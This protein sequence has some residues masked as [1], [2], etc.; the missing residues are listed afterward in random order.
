MVEGLVAV[1][2]RGASARLLVDWRRDLVAD[3]GGESAV[4]A[5][6]RALV[7]VITRTKLYV[8]HLDA[9]LMAQRSLVNK[10]NKGPRKH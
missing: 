7:E 1:D 5:Q 10:K 2:K 6:Q 3:L 8:D 4:T 9:F